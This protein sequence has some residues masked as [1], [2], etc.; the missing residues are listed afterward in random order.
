MLDLDE[1]NGI[2]L[3]VLDII[4]VISNFNFIKLC[5]LLEHKQKFCRSSQHFHTIKYLN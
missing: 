4:I 3:L 1:T 5:A 2:I